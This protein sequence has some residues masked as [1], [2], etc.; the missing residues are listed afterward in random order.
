M[1]ISNPF[2]LFLGMPPFLF[3]FLKGDILLESSP[4]NNYQETNDRD[5]KHGVINYSHFLSPFFLNSSPSFQEF[6]DQEFQNGP[7]ATSKKNQESCRKDFFHL[8]LLS[9]I[10]VFPRLY[11]W[12]QGVRKFLEAFFVLSLR[13]LVRPKNWD[14][15]K[16]KKANDNNSPDPKKIDG[17]FRWKHAA[18]FLESS[19]QGARELTHFS[20]QSLSFRLF[21]KFKKARK[22]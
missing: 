21:K 22:T 8:C 6:P 14:N 20:W 12:S 5:Q 4:G 3:I 10:S 1:L 9:S 18:S 17:A 11:V 16:N 7:G 13:P 2:L 19:P 15:E